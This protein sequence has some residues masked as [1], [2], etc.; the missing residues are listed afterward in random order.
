MTALPSTTMFC[1]AC[2]KSVSAT[3]H[4]C[5]GCGHQL[6]VAKS[7]ALAGCLG[8]A[9]GPVGLWYKGHWGAGIAWLVV[10]TIVCLGTGL[11]AAP[12]VWLGCGLHAMMAKGR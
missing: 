5:P 2:A 1:P 11:L 6:M 3:A 7:D 9:L 12:F 10:G 4:A 8:L